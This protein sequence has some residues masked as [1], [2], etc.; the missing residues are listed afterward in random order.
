VAVVVVVVEEAP[1]S[2][3]R[4]PRWASTRKSSEARRRPRATRSA[5]S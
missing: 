2:S 5:S 1:S 4:N 3:T